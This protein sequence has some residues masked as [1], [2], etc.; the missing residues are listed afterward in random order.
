[1]QAAATGSYPVKDRTPNGL[2]P[3][4]SLR[5]L[6]FGVASFTVQQRAWLALAKTANLLLTAFD[7]RGQ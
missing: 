5:R 4:P 7:R 6:G 1:M 3:R 2:K